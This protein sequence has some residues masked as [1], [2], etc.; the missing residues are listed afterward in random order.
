MGKIMKAYR[1][2]SVAA[3]LWWCHNCVCLLYL[4]LNFIIVFFQCSK[5]RSISLFLLFLVHICISLL[6]NFS[7]TPSHDFDIMKQLYV[8]VQVNSMKIR[9]LNLFGLKS[10][11]NVFTSRTFINSSMAWDDFSQLTDSWNKGNSSLNWRTRFK[12]V[13]W[14]QMLY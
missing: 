11:Y 2:F 10:N 6:R 9:G 4:S 12:Y 5:L 1:G 7:V 8:N 13:L 14:T 3:K